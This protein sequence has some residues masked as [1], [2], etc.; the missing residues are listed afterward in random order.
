M[1]E[2]I[3][4]IVPVY[5]VKEYIKRCV[6]SIINQTYKNIEII[7]VDDGSNDGSEGI[8]DAYEKN[9]NYIKVIHKENGGLSDAR[10]AGI[11][12]ARGKYIAFVDSD[13]YINRK[14]IEI[15]YKNIKNVDADISVCRP[16]Y[17]EDTEEISKLEINEQIQVFEGIDILRNMYNDYTIT[18]VAWNKLY[19]REVFE[20]IRYPKGKVIE[21]SAI[22]HYL[23]TTINKI[24]YSNL[25]L[26]Y[27]YQRQDSIMHKS[28]YK[29]LVELDW[30]NERIEYFKK[31]GYENEAFFKLTIEKYFEVFNNWMYRIIK[32]NGY[33]NKEMKKYFQ[34]CKKIYSLYCNLYNVRIKKLELLLELK[35]W[36][37]Y[38][39]G[40]KQLF[41]KIIKIGRKKIVSIKLNKRYK[42]Y[43]SKIQDKNKY[44]IFNTPIHGNIGDHA[45][46]FAEEQL[47]RDNNLN[48]FNIAYDEI[49]MFLNKYSS[50]VKD[51]DLIMITGGGFLGTL[52]ENEQNNVNMV[53]EKYNE[54]NIIIFPQTVFYDKTL[55]GTYRFEKEKAIYRNCKN[56][57]FCCRDKKSYEFVNSQITTNT[58]LTSDI[59][60]YLNYSKDNNFN[61]NDI[62]FCLRSDKEKVVSDDELDKMKNIVKEKFKNEKILF[63]DTVFSGYF[64]YK[65]GYRYFSKYLSDL[66]KTKLF[67]TDRLHGM[68]FATITGTPCIAM[69]NSSGKVKGVYEWISKNNDYVKFIENINEFEKV[70]NEMDI[71]KK[72]FY[73]N[74]D[75]I[76]NIEKIILG[77]R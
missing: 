13:D 9:Y 68:I 31:M 11:D 29:L 62:V 39:K 37:I 35:Q 10:N 51:N 28:D 32:D 59:V 1:E 64:S 63:K 25:E 75:I 55:Y 36:F 56:L 8:C 77:A 22:I 48:S 5:N 24:V 38:L 4:I 20:K 47:L 26:Y 27:Y 45:I 15:L 18:V 40:L 17:F 6:D 72:Y 41:N 52:W 53:L 67:I 16:Y 54:N 74:E 60:T 70:I 46:L 65:K 57:L 66:K 14:M 34:Q 73:N 49:E 7:L 21:D 76:N 33:K 69:A 44:L 2:L 3:S 42:K 61:R 23:L 58:L 30:I 43:L 50:T 71:N 12:I 19:K